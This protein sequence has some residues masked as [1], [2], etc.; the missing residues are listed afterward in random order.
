MTTSTRTSR[1]RGFLPIAVTLVVLAVGCSDDD[2]TTAPSTGAEPSSTTTTT[3]GPTTTTNI[4]ADAVEVIPTT[5]AANSTLVAGGSLWV[6]GTENPDETGSDTLLRLDPTTAEVVSRIDVGGGPLLLDAVGDVLWVTT[7]V[8]LARVDM[9]TEDVETVDRGGPGRRLAASE[10][11][12]WVEVDRRG[13][14]D[15]DIEAFDAVTLEPRTISVADSDS[16][17][18]LDLETDG[19][20]LWVAVDDATDA[21]QVV[22]AFDAV[23]DEP[24]DGY[25]DPWDADPEQA[26][27]LEL[28]DDELWICARSLTCVVSAPDTGEV[29]REVTIDVSDGELRELT[30]GDGSLW[31]SIEIQG[32]DDEALEDE[33]STFLRIDPATGAVLGPLYD[34]V[35]PMPKLAV[36]DGVAFLVSP[37]NE[38]RFDR[39]LVRIDLG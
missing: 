13:E 32:D 7:S 31:A 27:I 22:R 4:P 10:Q 11:T 9:T 8:G 38:S 28:V 30:S 23:T 29:L 20:T 34:A 12:V 14:L 26:V 6:G 24:L 2:S 19:E 3:T 35:Y 39:E 36:G 18:V 21:G 15:S 37:A 33:T 16:V 25:E 17:V 5:V 1:S